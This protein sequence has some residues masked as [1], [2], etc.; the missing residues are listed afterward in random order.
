MGKKCVLIGVGGSGAKVV[1]AF[2]YLCAAGFM[3]DKFGDG[4]ILVRIADMDQTGGNLTRTQDAISAY[5]NGFY[6]PIESTALNCP[7][8][9]R[10]LQS[11]DSSELLWTIDMNE[12][13]TLKTL[14]SDQS[15]GGTDDGSLSLLNTL[16][17]GAHDDS[18][19]KKDQ[20]IKLKIGTQ[21]IPRIG[22]V[23][24]GRE[25]KRSVKDKDG[26]TAQGYMS[27]LLKDNA[28][29]E[30]DEVQF[31]FVGSMVGGTGASAIPSIVKNLHDEFPALFATKQYKTGIILMLPYFKF[32]AFKDERSGTTAGVDPN[33]FPLNCKVA[34]RYYKNFFENNFKNNK[35]VVDSAY[36]IG[37]HALDFMRMEDGS[38]AK[39][40]LG[41]LAQ[42]NP[43]MPAEVAAATSIMH[44]FS[45]NNG[46]SAKTKIIFLK[47][48][49]SDKASDGAIAVTKPKWTEF[50]YSKEI[51][52]ALRRLSWFSLMWSHVVVRFAQSSTSE[53]GLIS[54]SCKGGA[55]TVTQDKHYAD[56]KR[57]CDA[58]LIWMRQ[59]E[60]NDFPIDS[61]K[62]GR[63]E[64]KQKHL[65]K[66]SFSTSSDEMLDKKVNRILNKA[67]KLKGIK[68]KNFSELVCRLWA[69]CE[70]VNEQ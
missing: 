35:N 41:G 48:D 24:W 67:Q 5:M 31:V 55:E 6:P 68:G 42:R 40:S 27:A 13:A 32:N 38:Y 65:N 64:E 60:M 20:N 51:R 25:Y 18:D 26:K 15:A 45:N 43:A 22:A 50:P 59:L 39:E 21:G 57:F 63:I 44:Y 49:R 56:M 62:D 3:K 58:M 14:F 2:T 46:D 47:N 33:D 52:T 17:N 70:N 4:E 36:F 29:D 12:N 7:V 37:A 53:L 9:F 10:A 8:K 66:S 19:P 1:E 54:T 69:A 11:G 34:L 61:K 23:A 28:I 16:F 30:T